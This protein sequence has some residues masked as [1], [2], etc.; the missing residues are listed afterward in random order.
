M[1]I[2]SWVW[3]RCLV[4]PHYV[5]S[6]RRHSSPA[7]DKR[8]INAVTWLM[9]PWHEVCEL[10][11]LSLVNCGH[12]LTF[13]WSTKGPRDTRANRGSQLW[14]LMRTDI[15]N[16]SKYFPILNVWTLSEFKLTA[17]PF[18]R[19]VLVPD[20]MYEVLL[21]SIE[22]YGDLRQSD[23]ILK[24]HCFYILHHINEAWL[25]EASSHVICSVSV[26]FSSLHSTDLFAFRIF[27]VRS[28]ILSLNTPEHSSPCLHSHRIKTSGSH[29]HYT[30]VRTTKTG[31]E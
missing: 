6:W 24:K 20:N 17:A 11:V 21:W 8:M 25:K 30:S 3:S 26:Q 13:D 12:F 9:T 14:S 19:F 1:F 4:W 27:G 15:C 16:H 2:G 29:Q 18:S 22:L 7:P 28:F 10:T 31:K 23:L 5:S